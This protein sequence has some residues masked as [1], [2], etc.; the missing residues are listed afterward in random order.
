MDDDDLDLPPAYGRRYPGGFHRQ[1]ICRRCGC[2]AR[3]ACRDRLPAARFLDV[4]PVGCHWANE[5]ATLC[6]V[7]ARQPRRRRLRWPRRRS[8]LQPPLD[9]REERQ[10]WRELRQRAA[11]A[12]ARDLIARARRRAQTCGGLPHE[13]VSESTFAALA[14]LC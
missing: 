2:T 6:S 12:A 13:F 3:R 4:G 1:G 14:R 8:T 10:L 11:L 9:W 7:C 5:R